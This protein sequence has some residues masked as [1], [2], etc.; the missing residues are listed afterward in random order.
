[1]FG[2]L[3]LPTDLRFGRNYFSLNKERKLFRDFISEGSIKI[4]KCLV[5][6]NYLLQNKNK[7]FLTQHIKIHLI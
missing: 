2:Q 6:F 1:M 3:R 4:V 5:I 7:Y